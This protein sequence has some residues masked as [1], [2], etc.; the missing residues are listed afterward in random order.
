[1]LR[2]TNVFSTFPLGDQ[3]TVEK[4]IEKI[5]RQLEIFFGP[6]EVFL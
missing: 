2:K 1:M 5:R 4:A 3:G 6:A